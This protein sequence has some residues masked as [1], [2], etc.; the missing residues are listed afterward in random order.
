MPIKMAFTKN[1]RRRIYMSMKKSKIAAVALCVLILA[2]SFSACGDKVEAVPSVTTTASQSESETEKQ[3]PSEIV[4]NE[5]NVKISGRTELTDDI[6]WCAHSGTGVEFTYAGKGFDL[7]IVGDNSASSGDEN[8]MARMAVYVDG[9]RTEDFMVDSPEKT[10]RIAESDH[11]KASDIKIVKLSESAQSTVGIK[12]IVIAEGESIEP[13]P[14]KKLK[15]EFIGDSI[16]CG[17]GVDDEVRDHHFSTTTEDIT[18]TYGY[19][20]AKALDADY[21]FVSFSGWGIIS[22]YTNDPDQK[23]DKQLV[24]LYYDK[25]GYSY[26]VFGESLYPQDKDWDFSRFKP[27]IIVINLGTNDNSYCKGNKDKRTEY[28]EEYKKFIGQVRTKNPD[29]DIFCA[30]GVMGA[31]LF[32]DMAE[33]AIT[34][35]EENND[36]KVHFVKL[37]TQDGSTGYA[38]D[39][40][41]TEAT[42]EIAA[43]YLTEEIKKAL[44]IT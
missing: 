33:A 18:K 22:G 2:S 10:V 25:L 26:K 40:H 27:D 3:G 41:P 11:E 32:D 31:E 1:H 29:A 5:E 30:L 7:V 42:H 19:K 37:P 39:W 35:S 38:A 34:F 16:T 14:E 43:E 9:E 21:S 17:Y 44:E 15:I 36:D 20:T 13:T 4:M 24:P 8:S 28:M 12:P 23:A 6:L